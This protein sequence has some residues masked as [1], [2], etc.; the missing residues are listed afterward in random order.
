MIADVSLTNGNTNPAACLRWTGE[1]LSCINSNGLTPREQG[2]G[3]Q[4][5]GRDDGALPDRV[6]LQAGWAVHGR[7]LSSLIW[8]GIDRPE[9]NNLAGGTLC[10][11][12]T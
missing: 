7:R 9:K 12:Q 8:P 11:S 6:L 4:H 3:G 2:G 5:Y 1:C 10:S